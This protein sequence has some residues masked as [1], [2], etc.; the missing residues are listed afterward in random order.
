MFSERSGVVNI[1]LEGMMLMGA[2]FGIMGADKT[3][4]WEL[5]LVIGVLAGAALA[6]V[7]ALF[8]ITL[9]TDQIVGGTAINFLALAHDVPL[10]QDLR[11][12]G[13]AD[14]P[15]DHPDISLGFLD[16]IPVVGNFDDVF[17]SST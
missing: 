9:R 1:G 6:F 2:F 13:R 8:S 5:G 4:S 7:H 10:P 3:G 15:I 14:R 11:G 12:A 16:D 17:G